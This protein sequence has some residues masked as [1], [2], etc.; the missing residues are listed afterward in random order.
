MTTA[1]DH[2][3][4]RVKAVAEILKQANVDWTQVYKFELRWEQINVAAKPSNFEDW[5]LV[6]VIN[7]ENKK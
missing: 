6:P 1:S 4:E 7:I 3:T 2:I 5:Q